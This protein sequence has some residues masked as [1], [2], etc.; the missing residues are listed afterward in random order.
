MSES[1]PSEPFLRNRNR[2]CTIPLN[3]A[4]THGKPFPHPKNL[5]RLLLRNNL[6]RQKQK[7][8]SNTKK[9]EP[10]KVIFMLVLEHIFGGSLKITSENKTISEGQKLP[11]KILRAELSKPK[12]EPLE[13][14]M[15]EL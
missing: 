2:N 7:K 4:E 6:V 15:R 12:P 1:E 8:T 9:K 11:Q 14:F 13:P 10:R 5:L 3:C